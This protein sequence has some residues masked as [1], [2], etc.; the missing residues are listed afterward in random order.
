MTIL[1]VFAA[2]LP[3]ARRLLEHRPSSPSDA[4]EA[5]SMTRRSIVLLTD[6]VA[7]IV[8]VGGAFLY[9]RYAGNSAQSAAATQG[10]ALVGRIHQSWAR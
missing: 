10:D 3:L 4:P 9:D 1:D 6:L 8:F 2:P 7:L 5:S